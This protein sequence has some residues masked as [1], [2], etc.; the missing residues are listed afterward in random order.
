MQHIATS[1][2][3]STKCRF[4]VENFKVRI[5]CLPQIAIC[6]CVCMCLCIQRCFNS[7]YWSTV[8]LLAGYTSSSSDIGLVISYGR[9]VTC[10]LVAPRRQ[11]QGPEADGHFPIK[12]V[13]TEWPPLERR[14]HLRK[15]F[16]FQGKHCIMRWRYMRSGPLFTKNT[17]FYWYRDPHYKVLYLDWNFTEVCS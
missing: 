8:F 13:S 10:D 16:H 4:S 1:W 5:F 11:S 9:H 14:D 17:L 6:A 2:S 7:R 12:I 15:R 3:Q